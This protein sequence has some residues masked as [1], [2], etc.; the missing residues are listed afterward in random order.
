MGERQVRG[1]QDVCY[2]HKFAVRAR[3]GDGVIPEVL[4]GIRARPMISRI[5]KSGGRQFRC[6]LINQQIDAAQKSIGRVG[7]GCDDFRHVL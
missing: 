2:A 7:L 6:R 1:A 5:S 3:D 4:I